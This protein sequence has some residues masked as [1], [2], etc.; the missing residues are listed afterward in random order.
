MRE[1]DDG[2][3]AQP[4]AAERFDLL[5]DR[6]QQRRRLV[7]ADDTRRVGVER[8]DHRRTAALD[9]LAG[10]AIDDLRVPAMQSVEVADGDDWM[11]P[12]GWT[13]IVGVANH[14]E[15]HRRQ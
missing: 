11:P 4:G 1:M 10:D 2:H 6:H 9:R 12:L 13:R 8:Q 5:R 15:R 14:L 3:A 7:G